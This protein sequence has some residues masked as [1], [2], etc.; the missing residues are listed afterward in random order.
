MTTY[1]VQLSYAAYYGHDAV[2]EANTLSEALD[3]AIAKAN[4]SLDWYSQ[5]V[6]GNT[7]IDA[8][9]EGD[10][11]LWAEDARQLSVPARF[12]EKG[13]GPRVIVIVAG[14]VVQGVSIDGGYARVE[15]RAYDISAGASDPTIR[16]DAEGRRYAFSDW[17]NVIPPSDGGG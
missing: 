16:T 8:A 1:T 4:E 6:C 14:G 9:S 13:E 10:V 12:T 17:S 3:K 11:D 5:D 7:F 15:V 2:V